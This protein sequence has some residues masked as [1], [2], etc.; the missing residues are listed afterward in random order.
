MISK[1][2]LRKL[3]KEELVDF[4]YNLCLKVDQLIGEVK[5]LREK[6]NVLENKKNSG[7]SS[8]PPS[9]DLFTLKNQSLRGKSGKKPGGQPGHKGETL[10]M[11]ADPDKIMQHY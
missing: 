8:L 7:N 4:A 5:E 10:R 1:D 9:S 3:D 2:E 6:I 11:T